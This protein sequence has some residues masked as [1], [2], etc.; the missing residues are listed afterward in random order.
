MALMDLAFTAVGLYTTHKAIEAHQDYANAIPPGLHIQIT[1]T[2]GIFCNL[3]DQEFRSVVPLAATFFFYA[4]SSAFLLA[5]A[6]L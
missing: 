3:S 1:N 6:F 2:H 4:T 5:R